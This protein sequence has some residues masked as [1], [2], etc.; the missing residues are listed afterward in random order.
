M[1]RVADIVANKHEEVRKYAL[2]P[3]DDYKT[4]SRKSSRL[5]TGLGNILNTMEKFWESIRLG[6]YAIGQRKG[7]GIAAKQ[8]L[9]PETRSN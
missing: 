7:L 8:P 9:R 1:S 3:N 4:F 5:A 2:C 6:T